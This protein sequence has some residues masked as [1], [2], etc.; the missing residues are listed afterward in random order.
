MVPYAP[1]K[2]EAKCYA[3]DKLIAT[4][5]VET[6]GPP[7][8]LKLTTDRTGL[9]ADGEDVTMVEVDVVDAQGRVVPTAANVVTFAAS[10]A[11]QIAGVGNG[12]PTCHEPDKASARSAFQGKCM[13][14][15]GETD[16]TGKATL[17]A[18]APGLKPAT[19]SLTI[20]K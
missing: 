6:A 7:A 8:A 2:L 5:T 13:V 15:V 3:G 9:L 4:D 12:D 20:S 10:G 16:R 17:T 19:L 1:G 14:L 18:S 11:A